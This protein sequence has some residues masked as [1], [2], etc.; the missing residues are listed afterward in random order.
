[1]RGRGVREGKD[2]RDKRRLEEVVTVA[3][4]NEGGSGRNVVHDLDRL[5]IDRSDPRSTDAE[6]A[7]VAV[8]VPGG[9]VGV[10]LAHQSVVSVIAGMVVGRPMAM[11]TV[12]TM[13]TVM[14]R[15]GIVVVRVALVTGNAGMTVLPGGFTVASVVETQIETDGSDTAPQ[16]EGE[17][18]HQGRYPQPRSILEVASHHSPGF[19]CDSFAEPSIRFSNSPHYATGWQ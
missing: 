3:R 15:V 18:G 13:V 7:E 10:A 9:M 17:A 14:T 19:G 11:M 2:V 8:P 1:M 16:E 4:W 6:N 12:V 5:G